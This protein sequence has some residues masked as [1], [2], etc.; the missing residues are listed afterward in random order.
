MKPFSPPML[1]A[2]RL[3]KRI[4]LPVLPLLRR[5]EGGRHQIGLSY[6]QRIEN[7]RGKFKPHWAW[8]LC[9]ARVLLVDDVKTTGATLHECARMLRAAG[10]VE[11]YGAVVAVAGWD[12]QTG[13]T[14]DRVPVEPPLPSGT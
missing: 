12:P 2:R 3:G 11:V 5:T 4:G 7:V 9:N 6:A 13:I 8:R 14:F 10:A 1:L